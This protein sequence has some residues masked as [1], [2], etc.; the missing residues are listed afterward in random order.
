MADA[1]AYVQTD[2]PG[3]SVTSALSG[4]ALTG[5]TV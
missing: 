4:L 5:A 1:H 3:S 2:S